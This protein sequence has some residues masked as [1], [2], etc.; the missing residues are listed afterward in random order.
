MITITLITKINCPLERVFAYTTNRANL[1]HWFAGVHKVV[2]DEPNR[3]GTTATI[4]AQL[5]GLP[6]SFA[7]EIVAYEPNR[8]YAVKADKPFPLLESETF[9]QQG[10]GTQIDYQGTFHTPGFSR[11]MNPLLRWLFKRQLV[12]SFRKLRDVLESDEAAGYEPEPFSTS[13][14]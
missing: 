10:S 8:T 9:T 4:T 3:I 5:L 14:Q 13:L 1:P 7:S 11:I 12:T 2:Q 6:F